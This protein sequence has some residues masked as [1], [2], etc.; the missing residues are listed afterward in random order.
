[1]L[2]HKLYAIVRQSD[3]VHNIS[4][5]IY[6]IDGNYEKY[7]FKINRL[8]DRKDTPNFMKHLFWRPNIVFSII[9]ENTSYRAGLFRPLLYTLFYKF[10]A[11]DVYD[12]FLLFCLHCLLH[13]SFVLLNEKENET[14]ENTPFLGKY[15]NFNNCNNK[16]IYEQGFWGIACRLIKSDKSI[17]FKLVETIM[18]L[19]CFN[20]I[21]NMRHYD[22]CFFVLCVSQMF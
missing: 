17:K 22:V 11:N 1:M 13:L 10:N 19:S 14:A 5:E 2:G 7:K 21:A 20:G 8:I 12:K 6:K 15:L 3:F 4:N 9:N 16:I 18:K